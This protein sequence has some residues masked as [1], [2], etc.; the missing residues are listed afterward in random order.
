MQISQK[1]LS[2]VIPVYRGKEFLSEL[3]R[4][5]E[6]A[7][8][9]C[10][11]DYELLLVNDASPDQCWSDI[12]ELC[13]S[14]PHIKGI[15]LSRNFGQHYAI[16]AGL[17]YA[18]GEWI[19]VMDC[20]LQ[21]RPEEIPHLYAKACEGYDSVLAQRA[22][23]QDSWLK[24]MQSRCFY[25]LFGYLT[26]TKMDAS[27]ANF[28]IYHRKV[29]NSILAMGDR[30]RYFP[31]MVQWVGFKRTVLPVEHAPRSS[32][33]SSYTLWKLLHLAFDT[34]I[35]FSDKPLRLIMRCGF[36]LSIGSFLLALV[37]FLLAICG[38]FKVA[39]FASIIFSVWF[40][41]GMTMLTLGLV[42]IYVGKVFQQVKQRPQFI[43]SD[44]CN[45]EVREQ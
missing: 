12:E 38:F 26:N 10:F 42:G 5:V 32:G 40:L 44:T 37:Y 33:S 17:L 29:I 14:N 41:G 3:S 19:V 35:S 24:R 13:K 27:I 9:S 25:A 16:T 39:G 7:A 43:I 2:I 36:L 18:T 28:G 15:N 11:V 31:T 4:R 21:D 20:D 34:I 23:R 6:V 30:I 1:P 22:E 45:L 8:Q